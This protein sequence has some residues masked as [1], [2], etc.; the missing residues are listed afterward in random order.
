MPDINSYLSSITVQV[1]LMCVSSRPSRPK[2]GYISLW[3]LCAL[4]MMERVT[5]LHGENGTSHKFRVVFVFL[6]KDEVITLQPFVSLS[7]FQR[8]GVSLVGE[9]SPSS[10][11]F[12]MPE[13][14]KIILTSFFRSYVNTFRMTA[15]LWH[16]VKTP[17]LPPPHPPHPFP[18]YSSI[19]KGK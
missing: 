19:C 4:I 13:D 12:V 1:D 9:R 14:G 18:I 6:R 8:C 5:S 11:C 3:W 2:K 15:V 16:C 7:F 17:L 10:L